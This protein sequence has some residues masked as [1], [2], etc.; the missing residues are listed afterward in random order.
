MIDVCNGYPVV[1][2]ANVVNHLGLEGAVAIAEKNRNRSIVV[3][4]SHQVEEAVT[5]KICSNDVAIRRRRVTHGVGRGP[6]QTASAIAH[7][8]GDRPRAR[9][10]ISTDQY[11]DIQI[12]VV[13]EVAQSHTQ[14]TAPGAGVVA[15]ELKS[16]VAVSQQHCNAAAAD[17]DDVRNTIAI[18]VANCKIINIRTGPESLKYC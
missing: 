6:G 10:A 2:S 15:Q 8:N 3:I 18:D 16:T 7:I 17:G 11:C 12:T 4:G 14:R 5:G 1:G 9:T 13:I